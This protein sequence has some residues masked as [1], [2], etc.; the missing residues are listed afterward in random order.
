LVILFFVNFFWRCP[1][2]KSL[3]KALET[4]AEYDRWLESLNA[5]VNALI[6][7]SRVGKLLP[8]LYCFF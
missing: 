8:A 5:C 4:K 3:F 1:D 6:K 2:L 7:K